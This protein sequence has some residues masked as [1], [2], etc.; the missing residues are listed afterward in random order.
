MH[1]LPQ[2]PVLL[3]YVPINI[4]K[5]MHWSQFMQ[6]LNNNLL[7]LPLLHPVLSCVSLQ[8]VFLELNNHN[9]WPQL[10]SIGSLIKKVNGQ[11]FKL[12]L[13]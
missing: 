1:P 5:S 13:V 4:T 11:L 8:E 10:Y 2:L 6:L 12:L 3:D 7:P 9:L